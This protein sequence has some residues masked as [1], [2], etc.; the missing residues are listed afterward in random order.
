MLKQGTEMNSSTNSTAIINNIMNIL[1]PDNIPYASLLNSI[2][3][4]SLPNT[5]ECEKFIDYSRS[6]NAKFD[7]IREML[8]SIIDW[9][10]NMKSK[11]LIIIDDAHWLD[12]CSWKLILSLT[13]K[14]T[15]KGLLIICLGRPFAN[16][17]LGFESWNKLIELPQ[18]L[19]LCISP[20]N[21][22]YCIELFA[23]VYIK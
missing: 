7:K 3:S 6:T 14:F 16:E 22:Q 15:S 4:I 5:E 17:T 20:L 11:I 8:I 12:S 10:L 23:Q 9:I 13:K 18:T 2:L 1:G 21:E 19:K